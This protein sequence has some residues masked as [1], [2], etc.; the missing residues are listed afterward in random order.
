MTWTLVLV[1]AAGAYAFKFLGLVVV[2]DRVLPPVLERCLALIPA[3]LIAALIVKDTLSVGHHL[4]VDARAA[5]VGAAIVAA[6]RKAPVLAVIIIGASVT[7]L[8]RALS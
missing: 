8:L 4:V 7:A 6:W 1:L 3:A 5:G 2:G